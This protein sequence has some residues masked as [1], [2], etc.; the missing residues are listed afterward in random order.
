M[1]RGIWDWVDSLGGEIATASTGVS[2]D[3]M[4]T[5]AEYL[6][7]QG[8]TT[9]A[10]LIVGGGQFMRNAENNFLD[11]TYGANGTIP[12]SMLAPM[13]AKFIDGMQDLAM[14]S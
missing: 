9:G 12:A 7:S 8:I 2:I 11:T 5:I 10:V 14:I 3:D 4:D 6:E 1:G 13:G